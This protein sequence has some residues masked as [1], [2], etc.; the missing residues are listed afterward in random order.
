MVLIL[1]FFLGFDCSFLMGSEGEE[2]L[3]K[4]K[5]GV[6]KKVEINLHV[7]SIG[8][9]QNCAKWASYC[10]DAYFVPMLSCK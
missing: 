7:Q 8:C 9:I 3:K 4:A 1:F 5:D 10:E 2:V 6:S